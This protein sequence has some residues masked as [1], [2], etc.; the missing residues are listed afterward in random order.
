VSKL[1][2]NTAIDT[3]SSDV[4]PGVDA[5]ITYSQME[6]L[7]GIVVWDPEPT[8]TGLW[9]QLTEP[10]NGAGLAG[11]IAT[12]VRELVTDKSPAEAH[13]L[14]DDLV[15]DALD[16]ALAYILRSLAASQSDQRFWTAIVTLLQLESGLL[17]GNIPNSSAIHL[18]DELAIDQTTLLG[19]F[20]V[21]HGPGRR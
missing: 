5:G 16:G 13:I 9:M 12:A 14:L 2:D 10:C 3:G 20:V 7:D 6:S 4:T 11:T 15:D 8:A 18:F 19:A 21:R 1:S 17:L